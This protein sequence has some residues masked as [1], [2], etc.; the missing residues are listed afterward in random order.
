MYAQGRYV[1]PPGDV[2]KRQQYSC[3]RV[4]DGAKPG[5]FTVVSLN[6]MDYRLINEIFGPKEG[7]DTPV[8]YTHLW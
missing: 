5:A 2:Y 7:N 4:L 6:L 3:R 8:S 1:C